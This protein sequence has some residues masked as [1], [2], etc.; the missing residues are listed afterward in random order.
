ME[1]TI[2]KVAGMSCGGCVSSVTKVLQGLPGV[3]SATV[4][5]E[6]GEAIVEFESASVTRHALAQ[7]VEDA[8]FEA[9]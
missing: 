7:A 2:I 6:R 9:S 3:A 8:G 1:T 4:S 5:L